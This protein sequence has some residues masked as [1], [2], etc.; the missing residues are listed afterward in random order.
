MS[1]SG[2]ALG[3]ITRDRHRALS[4]IVRPRITSAQANHEDWAKVLLPTDQTKRSV[5]RDLHTDFIGPSFRGSNVRPS[6]ETVQLVGRQVTRNTT[7]TARRNDYELDS[8]SN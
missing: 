1:E 6:Q 8:S 7:Q 3:S 4:L 5:Q 2:S